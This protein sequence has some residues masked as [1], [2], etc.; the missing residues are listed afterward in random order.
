MAKIRAEH[1]EILGVDISAAPDL[2]KKDPNI[3]NKLPYTLAV[4]KETLRLYPTAS[5][6]REGHPD[7]P[8][9]YNGEVHPTAGYLVLINQ[10]TMFRNPELYPSP[11]EFIPERFL[12]SPNNFQDVVKDSFRPFEKGPRA[13]I[14]QE[15]ALMEIKVFLALTIREFDFKDEYEENDRRLGREKPGD[16]LDGKRGMF[17]YRAYSVL[18]ASAKPVDGM[19]MSVKKRV[20]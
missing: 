18:V 9:V 13:C 12:P 14:G 15:L 1:D 19:P 11:D 16:T 3:I 5:S 6:A 17:G 2:L 8:V 7:V 20:V 4:I 10:H